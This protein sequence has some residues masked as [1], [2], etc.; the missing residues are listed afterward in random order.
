MICLLCLRAT[1]LGNGLRNGRG[2]G[3]TKKEHPL[4]YTQLNSHVGCQ[5]AHLGELHSEVLIPNQR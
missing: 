4:E 3:E 2:K 1:H 5:R